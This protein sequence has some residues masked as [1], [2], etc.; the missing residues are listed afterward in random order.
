M[1]TPA[2][3]S[4]PSTA[5]PLPAVTEPPPEEAELARMRAAPLTRLQ[6]VA[7]WRLPQKDRATRLLRF[8]DLA[9]RAEVRGSWRRADFFW[10]G[11]ERQLRALWRRPGPDTLTRGLRTLLTAT[12]ESYFAAHLSGVSKPAPDSR[13]FAHLDHVRKLASAP[14]PAE[15]A[16]E[17]Y[18]AMLESRLAACLQRGRTADTVAAADEL[19]KRFPT[20]RNQNL[21]VVTVH[22]AADAALSHGSDAAT[23]AFNA[24]SLAV[25]IGRLEDLRRRYPDNADVYA[26]LAS[27]HR[28]RAV[29]LANSLD[30]AEALAEIEKARAHAPDDE[31]MAT[32]AKELEELMTQR[33]RQLETILAEI[34]RTPN[35]ELSVAGH[36]LRTDVAKGTTARDAYRQSGVPYLLKGQAVRA[37]ALSYFRGVGIA[38]PEEGSLAENEAALRKGIERTLTGSPRTATEIAKGWQRAVKKDPLLSRFDEGS[39]VAALAAGLPGDGA[40]VADE[41]TATAFEAPRLPLESRERKRSLEPL[42]F[43]FWSREGLLPKTFAA[44]SLGLAVL[45]GMWAT[46]AAAGREA[47]DRTF[48]AMQR[49]FVRQDYAEAADAAER[50]LASPLAA[51]HPDA[52][53]EARGIY[54]VSLVELVAASPQGIDDAT[55]RR[56]AGYRALSSAR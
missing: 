51:H 38:A 34:G 55:S 56:I 22:R 19:V 26:A 37:R 15:D 44:V 14:F 53:D 48:Q 42:A 1:A 33:R 23:W 3:D 24:R 21:A 27:L 29:C 5:E 17:R 32:T 49:S 39:V 35:A 47:R 8:I 36:Q 40:E 12:H 41:A 6:L 13:A 16:G 2:S 31:Q 28:T 11:A 25:G 52:V 7:G 4:V 20:A 9:A 45:C 46:S 30:V 18:A 50:F 10:R 43:W 54:G